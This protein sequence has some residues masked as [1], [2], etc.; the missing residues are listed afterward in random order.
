MTH[1]GDGDL[2]AI[3]TYLA[4]YVDR[5]HQ[6]LSWLDARIEA[7]ERGRVVMSIPYEEK[8]TNVRPHLAEDDG[9]RPEVNGGVAATLIDTAGGF[10]MYPELDDHVAGGIATIN[11][12][13]NYL[14]R[15][16]GDLAATAEVVRAGGTIGVSQVT[17]VAETV[18]GDEKPVATGQGAYR[19]F[20]SGP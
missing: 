2:E 6:F 13:V 20:R 4:E 17:V 18:D 11:L 16:T 1:A 3:R 8:I 19:L 7:V 10:A 14:R 12:N 5:H 9:H 15:A